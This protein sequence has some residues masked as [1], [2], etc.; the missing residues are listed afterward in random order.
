MGLS[1]QANITRRLLPITFAWQW[2]RGDGPDDWE[3]V[4]VVMPFFEENNL[5]N[6]GLVSLTSV[7]RKIIV[8]ILTKAVTS[9]TS[10]HMKGKNIIGNGQRGFI[11]G[12]WCLTKLT[13]HH[14][15]KEVDVI[16]LD[17]SKAFNTVPRST[18]VEAALERYG[19]DRWTIRWVEALL[20][21]QRAVTGRANPTRSWWPVAFLGA[22]YWH[23][24]YWMSSLMTWAMGQSRPLASPWTMLGWG[25]WAVL[26][27]GQHKSLSKPWK[28]AG[29]G[30]LDSVRVGAKSCPG[31]RVTPS[32]AQAGCWLTR[33]QLCRK[34]PGCAGGHVAPERQHV[35]A[36]VK[37]SHVGLHEQEQRQHGS[38]CAWDPEAN[39]TVAHRGFSCP[40]D[41]TVHR[42]TRNRQEAWLLPAHRQGICGLQSLS[43]AQVLHDFSWDS[44]AV[45]SCMVLLN[46]LRNLQY[47]WTSSALLDLLHSSSVLLSIEYW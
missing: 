19:L 47:C 42:D 18:A 44:K 9:T 35:L 27:G 33:K 8:W 43:E 2:Q 32:I 1:K 25:Q 22:C 29:R 38:P 20:D 10:R 23:W 13:E 46:T 39:V 15:I 37:G 4:R 14:Q 11:K 40:E 36:M 34:G 17:V 45:Y 28:W 5:R 30:L 24:C 41:P 3:K 26:E 7:H 21:C 6:Y 16:H 31:D 12:K